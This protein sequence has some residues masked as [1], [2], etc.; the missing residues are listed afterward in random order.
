MTR[1]RPKKPTPDERLE[2]LLKAIFAAGAPVVSPSDI[3]RPMWAALD[4]SHAGVD[5]HRAREAGIDWQSVVRVIAAAGK[6]DVIL[7]TPIRAAAVRAALAELSPKHAHLTPAF[8]K[9][10]RRRRHETM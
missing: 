1:R 3:A 4:A 9:W 8:I 10:L 5:R 2:P 6:G 7:T